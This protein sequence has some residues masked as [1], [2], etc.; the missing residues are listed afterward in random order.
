MATT[1]FY[2]TRRDL[3]S[4][5]KCYLLSSI[6]PW[7]KSVS[8]FVQLIGQVSNLVLMTSLAWFTL[9]PL[10]GFYSS[11]IE[12]YLKFSTWNCNNNLESWKV[13]E[14][15]NF[16]WKLIITLLNIHWSMSQKWWCWKIKKFLSRSTDN[17][18]FIFF[19][20]DKI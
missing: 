16:C 4:I 13:S 12:H 6:W 18:N 3:V 9:H 8:I 1:L 11:L 2:W 10:I 5:S 19:L 14:T 20:G 7:L 15:F 17:I